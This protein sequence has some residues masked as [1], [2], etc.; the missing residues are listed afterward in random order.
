VR[1]LPTWELW[2]KKVRRL[3]R[4]PKNQEAGSWQG[5]VKEHVL[6]TFWQKTV[7]NRMREV[8]KVLRT[9]CGGSAW[10]LFLS[11]WASDRCQ[12]KAR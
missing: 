6:V 12:E 9:S 8:A 2:L 10:F 3:Q 4:R 7:S 1:K 5:S 11:I